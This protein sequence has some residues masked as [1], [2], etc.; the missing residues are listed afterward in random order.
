[1]IDAEALK[2]EIRDLPLI[3]ADLP[4]VGGTL[5][6]VPEDFVVTEILPYEACGEGEHVFARIRRTGL[7]TAEV[8]RKL[9]EALGLRRGA[10]S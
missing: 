2:E 6:S 4:G 9:G 1:M 3:T 5:K 10:I 7:A 8:S